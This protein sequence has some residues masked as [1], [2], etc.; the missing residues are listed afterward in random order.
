LWLDCHEEFP[1]QFTP[2][3]QSISLTAPPGSIVISATAYD[4]V[5]KKAGVEFEDIG[6][7]SLKNIIEPIRPIES[8]G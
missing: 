6:P 2:A 8:R 3:Q 4:Q 1:S 5:R 7:Q